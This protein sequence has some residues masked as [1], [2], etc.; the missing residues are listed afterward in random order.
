MPT[1]CWAA[2]SPAQAFLDFRIQRGVIQINPTLFHHP[3]EI[4]AHPVLPLARP[5]CPRT[6]SSHFMYRFLQ[7]HRGICSR[8]KPV[9]TVGIHAAMFEFG[10]SVFA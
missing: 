3:F 6:P 9:A 1:T 2:P 4:I 8:G 7:Q 10:Q 5:A